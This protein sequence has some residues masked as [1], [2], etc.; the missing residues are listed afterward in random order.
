MSAKAL[1]APSWSVPPAVPA[2]PLFCWA[3]LEKNGPTVAAGSSSS[4]GWLA[5]GAWA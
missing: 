4:H 5:M 2:V 1:G 3:S